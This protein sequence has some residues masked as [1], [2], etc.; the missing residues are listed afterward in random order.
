MQIFLAILPTIVG[1]LAIIIKKRVDKTLT[2]QIDDL[3]KLRELQT[4]FT[5]EDDKRIINRAIDITKEEITNRFKDGGLDTIKKGMKNRS[6]EANFA[7]FVGLSLGFTFLA[8]AFI[9]GVVNL[10]TIIVEESPNFNLA[11]GYGILIITAAGAIAYDRLRSR[12]NN[13]PKSSKEE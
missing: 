7:I 13:R 11:F 1:F 5:I 8:T 3:A 12:Q 10:G 4:K 9:Q 6:N 2:S